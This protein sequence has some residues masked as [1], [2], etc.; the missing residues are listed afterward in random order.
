MMMRRN[1]MGLVNRTV[2]TLKSVMVLPLMVD[3]QPLP[4]YTES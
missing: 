3:E 4:E 1:K 2:V